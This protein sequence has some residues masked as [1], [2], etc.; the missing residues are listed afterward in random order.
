MV[1]STMDNGPKTIC[2]VLATTSMQMGSD[3][4]D[5]IFQ[6]KSKA[7]ASTPGPTEED[8][9]DGGTKVSNTDWAPIRTKN[10]Q[11]SMASGRM[12][13]VSSGSLRVRWIR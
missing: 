8:M 11:L 9:R 2:K 1:K 5:S 3:M 6:T 12:E 7:T 4:M 13:N 10:Q